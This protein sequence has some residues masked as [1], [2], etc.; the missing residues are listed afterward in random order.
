[1]SI[2]ISQDGKNAQRIDKSEF[3]KEGYLQNY[4]RENPDSIPIYEIEEDKKLFVVAREFST[5]S[6]DIDALATTKS[7]LI[8]R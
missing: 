2:I 5:E 8:I 4:I 7:I 3:E 1:M 6:G